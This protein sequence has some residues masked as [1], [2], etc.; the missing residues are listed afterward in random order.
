MS[1]S[2]SSQQSSSSQWDILKRMKNAISQRPQLYKNPTCVCGFKLQVRTSWTEGN[3]CRRFTRC[4]NA[5]CKCFTWIDE[6]EGERDCC[7][8]L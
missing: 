3:P 1:S 5:V 4:E 2:Y 6:Q 8:E 7:E